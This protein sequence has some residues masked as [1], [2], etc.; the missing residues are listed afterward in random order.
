MR[1]Y[2]IN[3]EAESTRQKQLPLVS[4]K[5]NLL[6][7]MIEHSGIVL[8]KAT[9][10]IKHL[11]LDPRHCRSGREIF[12]LL[13]GVDHCLLRHDVETLPKALQYS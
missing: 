4:P 6:N 10:V 8:D 3:E 2:L 5:S 13:R 7:R 11:S 12:V 9:G 1:H